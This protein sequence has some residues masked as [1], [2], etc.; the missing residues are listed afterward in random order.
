MYVS[1]LCRRPGQDL[2]GGQLR[3]PGPNNLHRPVPHQCPNA[4]M[5]RCLY[6]LY[7]LLH[8]DECCAFLLN[9]LSSFVLPHLLLHLYLLFVVVALVC[10]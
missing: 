7:L 9:L 4:P 1:V 8:L 10:R 2:V 5:P 3:H 6:M